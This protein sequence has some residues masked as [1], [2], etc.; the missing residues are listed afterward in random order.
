VE[1]FVYLGL[2][3]DQDFSWKGHVKHLVSKLSSVIRE[4]NFA[5]S[6]LNYKARKLIYYAL[7]HSHLN[8][9]I[10]AW[11]T[12]TLTSLENMQQKLLYK[13]CSKKHKKTTVN[14]FKFWKV[15]P[16]KKLFEYNV[17]C[18]KYF[19]SHGTERQH[20]YNT[21]MSERNPL[22]MPKSENKFNERTWQ[23]IVPRLWNSLPTEL[24]NFVTLKTVKYHVKKW[25][26][27]TM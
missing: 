5:K 1:T 17:L 15:L 14:I 9:G 2:H 23:Y 6:K 27:R 11:G 20:N 26:K 3:L 10:P 8:Y 13:M 22:I 16:V 4:M 18:L 12:A 21:R 24:K 7:A 19:E 25:L